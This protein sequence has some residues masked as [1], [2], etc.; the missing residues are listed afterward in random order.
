LT[1]VTFFYLN[2]MTRSS[3]ALIERKKCAML[4]TREKGQR[5]STLFH[6]DDGVVAGD[7]LFDLADL[8][9]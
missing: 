7:R 4:I 6:D 8:P 2:E 9:S 3:P 1:R 5:I